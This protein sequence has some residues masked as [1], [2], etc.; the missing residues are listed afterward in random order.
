ML[1]YF[2]KEAVTKTIESGFVTFYSRSKKRLWQKGESSGNK[3]KLISIAEDCDN[4]TLLIK[5]IPSGVVCHKGTM[6]CFK[7]NES[8]TFNTLERIIKDR[9]INPNSESYVSSLLKKGIEKVSQKVGEEAVEVVIASL[10]QSK[11]E[12]RGELA[13]LFFHTLV[14]MQLKDIQ[15]EDVLLELKNRNRH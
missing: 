5:A 11:D 2:N 6:T 8:F 13:D 7:E 1:G 15:L 10:S 3:L 14:L 4:D 9:K 12:L